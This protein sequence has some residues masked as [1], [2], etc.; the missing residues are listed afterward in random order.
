[1]FTTIVNAV[2]FLALV[3]AVAAIAT[4]FT[5]VIADTMRYHTK[6][7][8]FLALF[9]FFGGIVAVIAPAIFSSV[10]P[11]NGWGT[12]LIAFSWLV[13][14]PALLLLSVWAYERK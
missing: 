7:N 3:G 9:G 8:A 1:M 4:G 14:A 6:A 13:A 10:I 5:G 12:A 2:V 11:V